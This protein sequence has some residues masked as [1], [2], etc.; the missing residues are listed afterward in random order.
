MQQKYTVLQYISNQLSLSFLIIE[1]TVL[2]KVRC[3][4]IVYRLLSW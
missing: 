2:L 4:K 1:L 3:F